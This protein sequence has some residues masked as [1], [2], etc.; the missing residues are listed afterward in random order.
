MRATRVFVAGAITGAVFVW[1]CGRQIRDWLETMTGEARA[2][3]AAG[4]QAIDET[5]GAVLDR[6]SHALRRA[7]ER[8]QDTKE[9]VSEVLRAGQHAVRPPPITGD[10]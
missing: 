1:L 6:G 3:A 4:L 5:A 7:E 9:Q 10:P 8:V 2:R